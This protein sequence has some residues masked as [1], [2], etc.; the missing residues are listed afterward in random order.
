MV[1]KYKNKKGEIWYLHYKIGRGKNVLFYF[2]KDPLDALESL[3][4]GY[5]VVEGK[6]GVP[7]LKKIG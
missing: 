4:P 1:F 5:I 6:N 3:P 7:F 2:S